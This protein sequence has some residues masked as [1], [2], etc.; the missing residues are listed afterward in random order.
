MIEQR[1]DETNLEEAIE[2]LV[3][4]EE[5]IILILNKGCVPPRR[6]WTELSHEV[7]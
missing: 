7:Q 3:A 4:R 6:P 1:F 2:Q 5:V